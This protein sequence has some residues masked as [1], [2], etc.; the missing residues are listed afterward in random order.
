[1]PEGTER[2]AG[3]KLARHKFVPYELPTKINVAPFVFTIIIN[4]QRNWTC[5]Y[6]SGV[7]SLTSRCCLPL[8]FAI[9]KRYMNWE[10]RMFRGWKKWI[11]LYSRLLRKAEFKS[12]TFMF[13]TNHHRVKKVEH[14]CVRSRVSDSQIRTI[15]VFVLLLKQPRKR[16]VTAF[17]LNYIS[18]QEKSTVRGHRVSTKA[19]PNFLTHKSGPML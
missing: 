6:N 2:E 3:S 1:M 13:R 10:D 7:I 12:T 14:V 9:R 8:R 18:I 11:D 16:H 19:L 17:P 4:N 15:V 5:F